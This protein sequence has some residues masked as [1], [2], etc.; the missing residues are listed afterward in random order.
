M[1]RKEGKRVEK[2]YRKEKGGGRRGTV[3]IRCD[4]RGIG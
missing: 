3:G 4:V 1:K 2:G